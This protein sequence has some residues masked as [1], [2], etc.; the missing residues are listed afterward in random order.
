[1]STALTAVFIIQ[2]QKAAPAL[3]C[4][5]LPYFITISELMP[6]LLQQ[7]TAVQV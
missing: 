5:G 3:I 1:M 7:E 2:R 6:A 4:A